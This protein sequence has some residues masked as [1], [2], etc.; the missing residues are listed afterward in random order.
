MRFLLTF[1]TI[2]IA[3]FTIII[4]IIASCSKESLQENIYE[5][6]RK[7]N[8]NYYD[9][10]YGT[11][12]ATSA[13]TQ[14]KDIPYGV[15]SSKYYW[16]NGE[17]ITIS[18]VDDPTSKNPK[19]EWVRNVIKNCAREWEKYANINLKF[20]D[21][22]QGKAML[23]IKLT[24]QNGTLGGSCPIGTTLLS[25]SNQSSVYNMQIVA[26]NCDGSPRSTIQY[27]LDNGFN[28]YWHPTFIN[29]T[30]ENTALHEFG[31]LL[32]LQHM[33]DHPEE[34]FNLSSFYSAYGITPLINKAQFD[35]SHQTKYGAYDPESIMLYYIKPIWNNNKAAGGHA[36]LSKG[37]IE[38]IRYIYPGR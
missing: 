16:Q 2:S 13:T 1:R 34:K 20:I 22:N 35:Y 5:R 6:T 25:G 15:A 3:Y 26:Y 10:E 4:N 17:T 9:V 11:Y 19:E 36:K 30:I 12:P 23:R 33:H 28:F 24:T 8:G 32:G 29:S 7:V 27:L 14:Y 37:D 38:T 31:H 21:S 18:F